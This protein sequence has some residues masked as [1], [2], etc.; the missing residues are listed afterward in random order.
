MAQTA[1]NHA[2]TYILR[3]CTTVHN[4]YILVD[5]TGMTLKKQYV[6]FELSLHF[7]KLLQTLLLQLAIH[8]LQL[9]NLHLHLLVLVGHLLDV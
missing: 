1:R 4:I 8:L 3:V 5:T 7:Y 6:Y 9:D 2:R